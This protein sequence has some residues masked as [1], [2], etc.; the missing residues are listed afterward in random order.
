MERRMSEFTIGRVAFGPA[1]ALSM[2]FRTL[3]EPQ[4]GPDELA[5][6]IR[7]LTPAMRMKAIE[8]LGNLMCMHC[9]SDDPKCQCWNDE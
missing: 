3:V 8:A 5:R 9:G 4:L 2:P 1:P 6:R 7:A